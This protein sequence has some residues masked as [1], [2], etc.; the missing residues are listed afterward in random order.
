MTASHSHY[1]QADG[2]FCR[3]NKNPLFAAKSNH[4]THQNTILPLHPHIHAVLQGFHSPF[5]T[6]AKPCEYFLQLCRVELCIITCGTFNHPFCI[7][8]FADNKAFL[9]FECFDFRCQKGGTAFCAKL[10][11]HALHPQPEQ[12]TCRFVS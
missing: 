10:H 12:E 5:K 7:I 4:Q 3:Q 8:N 6:V 1:P 9:Q 11:F 2:D